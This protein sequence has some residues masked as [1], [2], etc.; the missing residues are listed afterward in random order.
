VGTAAQYFGGTEECEGTLDCSV[1]TMIRCED[2][3]SSKQL[4][5]TIANFSRP[6]IISRHVMRRDRLEGRVLMAVVT[7]ESHNASFRANRATK[8]LMAV[9]IAL[10]RLATRVPSGTVV[11]RGLVPLADLVTGVRVEYVATWTAAASEG[12]LNQPILYRQVLYCST[13]MRATCPAQPMQLHEACG[14]AWGPCG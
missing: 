12:C 3:R 11:R 4:R 13:A 10:L 7:A 2:S 8:R 5:M 14:F 6:A 9:V 1:Y